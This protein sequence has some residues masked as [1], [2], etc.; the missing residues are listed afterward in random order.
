M[1]EYVEF[2]IKR[3]ETLMVLQRYKNQQIAYI[4][5]DGTF[6]SVRARETCL[7]G[8]KACLHCKSKIY[9]NDF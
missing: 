1:N 3:K 2:I 8:M 9:F 5:K 4:A 6:H 7:P